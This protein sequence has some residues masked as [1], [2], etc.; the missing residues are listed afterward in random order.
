MPYANWEALIARYPEFNK[1]GGNQEVNSSYIHPAERELD[2]R[3]GIFFTVPF[4]SNNY[5]ATDLTLEIVYARYYQTLNPDKAELK[6][7]YIDS[8]ITALISGNAAMIAS[9]GGVIG[10]IEGATGIA[11]SNTMSYHP[12][13]GMGDI[14][15]FHADSAQLTYEEDV[16]G[17]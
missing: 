12:V 16:R 7:K 11:Y 3:L 17:F 10:A 1:L 4:S 15:D 13:F 2:S 14:A 8:R 9:S 5:T 6:Q